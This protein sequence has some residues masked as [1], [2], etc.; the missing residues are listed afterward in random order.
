MSSPPFSGLGG[1]DSVCGTRRR[2]GGVKFGLRWLSKEITREERVAAA[3]MIRG[4]QAARCGG[5]LDGRAGCVADQWRFE[6]RRASADKAPALDERHA[7]FRPWL[8]NDGQSVRSGF[9]PNVLVGAWP[10]GRARTGARQY[11]K[12]P[13]APSLRSSSI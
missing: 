6:N 12:V 7:E 8:A 1:R 13:E 10:Q 9:N 11:S 3:R 2:D 4:R 5:D